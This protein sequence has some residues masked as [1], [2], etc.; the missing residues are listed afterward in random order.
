MG[1]RMAARALDRGRRCLGDYAAE[2]DPSQPWDRMEAGHSFGSGSVHAPGARPVGD[3]T[4]LRSLMRRIFGSGGGTQ[5]PESY[6][7][8][9]AV[10]RTLG[11]SGDHSWRVTQPADV[12]DS[13]SGGPDA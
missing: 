12:V 4:R 8:G 10:A 1:A 2:Q 5:L 13:E 9:D 11:H 6:R 7:R 3:P